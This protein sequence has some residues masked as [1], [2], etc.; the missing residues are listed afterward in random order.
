[1]SCIWAYC[2]SNCIH[3]DANELFVLNSALYESSRVFM[4]FFSFFYRMAE[5]MSLN[6]H[7]L[8]NEGACQKNIGGGS[9]LFPVIRHGDLFL[10]RN[11]VAAI[12]PTANTLT[13]KI[14]TGKNLVTLQNN[15][16][17]LHKYEKHLLQPLSH[18]NLLA[19]KNP[20]AKYLSSRRRC[21]VLRRI[22]LRQ[23]S[24]DENISHALG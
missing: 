16:P 12:T 4:S 1:M 13:V 8:T 2:H 14:P 17:T 7:N 9:S 10:I 20:M 11:T 15:L 23:N 5:W 22:F 6:G 24:L 21:K 18:K 3:I 19:L